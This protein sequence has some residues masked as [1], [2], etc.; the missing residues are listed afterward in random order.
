MRLETEEAVAAI[1]AWADKNRASATAR[2]NTCKP[3]S[4]SHLMLSGKVKAYVDVVCY[5][6]DKYGAKMT[7][8]VANV[9]NKPHD[10]KP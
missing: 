9:V 6:R 1:F 2:R 10:Y 3:K 5:I 8:H 7:S 4:P